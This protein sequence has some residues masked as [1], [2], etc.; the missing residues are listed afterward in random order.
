[1]ESF[2]LAFQKFANQRSLQNN[3]IRQCLA[4]VGL[5]KQALNKTLGRT[6]VILP[7]PDIDD[8]M[9]EIKASLN[10][11]PLSN[12]MHICRGNDNEPQPR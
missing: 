5:I 9:Y 10:D 6:S 7:I 4:W 3:D 12:N 2:M 11:Q 8:T 1:M